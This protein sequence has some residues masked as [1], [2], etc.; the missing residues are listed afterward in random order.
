MSM[1]MPPSRVQ[2][3]S[4]SFLTLP[5]DGAV[6]DS[7]IDSNSAIIS[8]AFAMVSSLKLELISMVFNA[9]LI[10]DLALENFFASSFALSPLCFGV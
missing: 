8:C 7:I 1:P 4:L 5:S 3:R 10:A 9:I 2:S 6:P